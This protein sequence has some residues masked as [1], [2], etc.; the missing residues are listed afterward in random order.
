MKPESASRV[1]TSMSNNTDFIVHKKI[2]EGVIRHAVEPLDDAIQHLDDLD[3]LPKKIVQK[4]LKKAQ[5]DEFKEEL[6]NGPHPCLRECKEGEERMICY[7]HFSMEWYQ[8][9][10]KACYDCP[11]NQSDCYRQD[12]I[13][14]D[15]MNRALNVIN[16]KMPGPSIEVRI[17]KAC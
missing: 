10:S 5:H 16:R 17:Y 9:M 6:E 13:P 11:Y 14:A 3:Y 8:T 12:C 15:G 4:P 1:L 7:Y 2:D